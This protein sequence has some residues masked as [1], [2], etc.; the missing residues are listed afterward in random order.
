[1]RL[2]SALKWLRSPKLLVPSIFWG[3]VAGPALAW[4]II[5]AFRCRRG[6][7]PD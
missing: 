6:M 7:R 2:E 1:M 5:L 4:L 3:W